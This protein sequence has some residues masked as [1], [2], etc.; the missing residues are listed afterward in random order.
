MDLTNDPAFTKKYGPK[1]KAAGGRY[2]EARGSQHTRFVYLP[3]SDEELI[4]KIW[5]DFGAITRV[6]KKF[7]DEQGVMV[8]QSVAI[9][10]NLPAWVHV[11]HISKDCENPA[12]EFRAQFA[13]AILNARTREIAGSDHPVTW[14][15]KEAQE[16]A[17]AEK[18]AQAKKKIRIEAEAAVDAL[19]ALC[20]TPEGR[21]ALSKAAVELAPH[22]HLTLFVQQAK[23]HLPS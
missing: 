1:V 17:L 9:S 8:A 13:R 4:N 11:H 3:D 7:G 20:S 16:Q 23:K 19:A 22:S 14:A 21:E 2:S 18:Q 12:A 10:N 5:K 15:E 6:G